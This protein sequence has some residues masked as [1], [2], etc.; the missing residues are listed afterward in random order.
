MDGARWRAR[1]G[2]WGIRLLLVS[3]LVLGTVAVC[4]LWLFP[5]LAPYVPFNDQTVE[6]PAP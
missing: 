3:L 5:N 6:E 1:P 2:P 4:F